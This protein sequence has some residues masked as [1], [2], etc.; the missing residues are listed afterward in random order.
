MATFVQ[1]STEVKELPRW[2]VRTADY[3]SV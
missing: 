2:T 1:D 3:R